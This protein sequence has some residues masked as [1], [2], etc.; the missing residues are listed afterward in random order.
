MDSKEQERHLNSPRDRLKVLVINGPNLNRLGLREPDIYGRFTLVDLE[1]ILRKEGEV[2]GLDLDFFQS[3]SEGA[4]VD[5]I[6]QA[7]GKYDGIIINPGA[8]THYSIAIRDAIAGEGIPTVEIHIS[9]IYKREE[10][11]HHSFIAPVAIGQITG[12]G[13]YGYILAL[14]GLNTYLRG[15]YA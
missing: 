9:N 1:E 8:Y 12:F 4:I 5:V 3:N 10:F 14:Y 13:I 2:L 6:Q 11:R 15:N 7:K